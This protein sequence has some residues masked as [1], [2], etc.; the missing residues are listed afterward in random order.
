M[1]MNV[2]CVLR[3]KLKDILWDG[4]QLQDCKAIVLKCWDAFSF[5]QRPKARKGM[6]SIGHRQEQEVPHGTHTAQA[7]F[8]A[9]SVTSV[10]SSPS[11]ASSHGPQ[12]H[13]QCRVK[14]VHFI[15]GD[16]GLTCNWLRSHSCSLPSTIKTTGMSQEQSALREILPRD[17]N[18]YWARMYQKY[19]RNTLTIVLT[20]CP[21]CS[22]ICIFM[23]RETR[24]MFI[25]EYE[26]VK[27]IF[28]TFK[29]TFIILAKSQK[30]F[31]WQEQY[32]LISWDL[33]TI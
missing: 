28:E 27:L 17:S 4:R 13:A 30:L 26:I 8:P 14:G 10:S 15:W 1:K 12:F 9:L 21:A 25:Y 29:E 24:I 7:A 33:S 22:S 11:A 3:Q 5:L 6:E 31:L 16:K 2:M 18:F 23:I 32:P 19:Q 20:W